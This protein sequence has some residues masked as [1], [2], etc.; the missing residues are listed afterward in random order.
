[1]YPRLTGVEEKYT[2]LRSVVFNVVKA[3]V[4]TT[5]IFFW[6]SSIMFHPEKNSATGESIRGH[7]CAFQCQASRL[8]KVLL[9]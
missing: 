2:L 3:V 6:A 1:M 8:F 5:G 9:T 4:R 7:C